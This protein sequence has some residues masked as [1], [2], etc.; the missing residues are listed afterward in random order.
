MAPPAPLVL[1]RVHVCV[2]AR[3]RVCVCEGCSS[4]RCLAL[5][6]HETHFLMFSLITG[7]Q[8]KV[9]YPRSRIVF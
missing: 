4:C 8:N 2:R 1:T 7:P 9:V 3:T 6:E 5:N